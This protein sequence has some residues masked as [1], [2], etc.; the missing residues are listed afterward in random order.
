MNE[1]PQRDWLDD[2]LKEGPRYIEDNGFSARVVSALPRR[3][4]RAWV[5]TAVLGGAAVAGCAL[6]LVLLPGGK[7]V[8]DCALQLAT[9]RTL[10]P[11]LIM[12]ALI[13]A[14]LVGTSLI[15]VATEK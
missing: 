9:A 10:T 3:K 5:R 15:P 4:Q 6:G 7:F 14:A 1:Q 8:A 13:V 11:S 2:V 12:P